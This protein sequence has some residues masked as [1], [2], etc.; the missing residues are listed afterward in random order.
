MN[1]AI[2]YDRQVN[3]SV[4]VHVSVQ[5]VEEEDGDVV[6]AMEETQLPPLLADDYENGVPEIPDLAHIEEPQ[7]VSQGR[8]SFVVSNTRQDG[9]AVAV[10]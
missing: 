3:V 4:V 8:V 2:Q 6:I 7:Q 5:P 9:V 1:E 10:G